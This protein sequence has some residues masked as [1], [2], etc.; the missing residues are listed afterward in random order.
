MPS[1]ENLDGGDALLKGPETGLL[2][3]P[4]TKI[5]WREPQGFVGALSTGLPKT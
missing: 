5:H 4:A 2:Q 1:S 3:E